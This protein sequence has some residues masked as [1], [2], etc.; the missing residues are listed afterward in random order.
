MTDYKFKAAPEMETDSRSNSENRDVGN[1]SSKVRNNC[2]KDFT[3]SSSA[4]VDSSGTSNSIRE[5][6]VKGEIL[7]TLSSSQKEKKI[8][9]PIKRLERVDKHWL[10]GSS[11]VFKKQELFFGA[12]GLKQ[13]EKNSS[14]VSLKPVTQRLD[15]RSYKKLFRSR[16]KKATESGSREK[17]STQS[18]NGIGDDSSKEVEEGVVESCLSSS[19][20]QRVDFDLEHNFF[21]NAEPIH[22][23]LS[24]SIPQDGRELEA[25]LNT[26][27]TEEYRSDTQHK[28]S[29][30]ETKTQNEHTAC[31][32]CMNGGDL[33]YCGGKGCKRNYHLSCLDPPLSDK[34]PGVWYCILCVRKK[35]ELG[36]HSVS[37][38]VQSVWDA[39]EVVSDHE[40]MQRQKQYLV[41]YQGLAHVH[42][43]WIPE[44]QLLVEAPV[45]VAKFNRKNKVINWKAEWVLPQRVLQ[46]RLLVFPNNY[47]EHDHGDG[48]NNLGCQYE[49]LVKWTNLGYDH[50]T[51][52]L[53]NAS[54]L[55]SPEALKLIKEFENRHEMEERSACLPRADEVLLI[56]TAIYES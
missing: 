37:E 52:E 43:R 30:L 7:R 50:V 28:D 9:T 3:N 22:K 49:W 14:S 36:V 2:F 13:S 56:F 34:P 18:G 46:K 51:W 25:M 44:T 1:K 21:G 12:H 19:K 10:S 26:E 11:K 42:N 27:L 39:R 31:I 53:E 4:S 38:K 20:R 6:P 29:R 5:R 16:P 23:L 24:S 45:L 41:K 48:D 47:D 15:A 54:F 35:I 55:R 32:I 17:L 40:V 8:C 33:L